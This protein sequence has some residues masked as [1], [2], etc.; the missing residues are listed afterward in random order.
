MGQAKRISCVAH[1]TQLHHIFDT[2]I[3]HFFPPLTPIPKKTVVLAASILG[4]TEGFLLKSAPHLFLSQS[5][6]MLFARGD[7]EEEYVCDQIPTTPQLCPTH[8]TC[9]IAMGCFWSPQLE[10]S[11]MKGVKRVVVGYTG[12]VEP[13]PTYVTIKDS[14]EALL[15]EFDPYEISYQEILDKWSTSFAFFRSKPKSTQYRHILFYRNEEQKEMAIA[16]LEEVRKVAT[17]YVSIEPMDSFVFYQ[18]ED[19]HQNFFLK[20]R[21][22]VAASQ[23]Q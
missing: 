19:H 10:Y 7:G 2:F 11:A 17:A 14:S 3:L 22:K 20:S 16:K 15:F 21:A 5:F 23:V 13:N 18:G 8:E 4:T 6:G 1:Q 12:G 9:V